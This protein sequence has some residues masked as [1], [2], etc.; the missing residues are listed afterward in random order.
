MN[1]M[2]TNAHLYQQTLSYRKNAPP[3]QYLAPCWFVRVPHPVYYPR[4][5]CHIE[6]LICGEEVFERLAKDLL[7]ARESVDIITWGFDPGMV[8]VRGSTAE[9]G[10]R[11]GDLLKEIATRK[12]KPV[13]VRLLV[14]HDDVMSNELMKN[15][16]GYYGKRFPGID[17]ILSS[18]YSESH[19]AYNAEWF[20]QVCAGDIPNIT[21]HVRDVPAIFLPRSLSGESAPWNVAADLGMIYA[22]HHQKMLLVD[23]ELPK[24]AR[25]Y[26]MGHNSITDFWD[27]KE[28]QFR[29]KRRER[30]YTTDH[31]DLQRSAWKLGQQFDIFHSGMTEAEQSEKEG[32][33]QSYIDAHSHVAQPYQDVSCRVRG[34]ILYDLN[35]NFCQAW[36]E[37]RRPSPLFCDLAKLVWL[38]PLHPINIACKVVDRMHREMD[39]D[40]IARRKKLS[41]AAFDLP[42]GHHSL[43][44][45]RTQPQHGEKSVKECY[46]NLTRQMLHYIFIQNQYIQYEPWAE[47]LIACV[48]LLRAAGY[49][50]PIYVFLLTSTPEKDGMDRPTYGVASKVGRSESMRFEHEEAVEKAQKQKTK[51][52]I[53]PEELAVQGIKVFMGS[54]WTCNE[55]KGKLRPD[56]YEEIYIH[57]KVAIV[58]D[59]AFTI[60]SANLNL[61]SMALDS[62]LN[63]LS[64]AKD[65][66]YQLRSDLFSQCAQETG[67]EPFG[68]MADTFK[69]WEKLAV[70]N[71]GAKA[72]G[73]KL[74]GNLLPFHVDRKPGMPVV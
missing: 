50:Q 68:D 31:A 9:D 30:F 67:P 41:L 58:D 66:A 60:G 49:L 42:Y 23:Y 2:S 36:Q 3:S 25:G 1:T 51:P 72:A 18:Y 33:V 29:D 16:P 57:A 20:S 8:L 47:Y 73:G 17:C 54:L 13:K 34:P 37:S 64:E 56:D 70:K 19:Q 10:T 65:V 35:H 62:E 74:M 38:P 15:I 43:Q 45:L 59:A 28:H 48:G 63:V 52:P 32:A 22:A 7:S 46:A 4:Y 39:P 14:W 12:E 53:T 71:F 24:L 26:V 11:Y 21:F 5:N 61:R 69:K 27:T 6:P 44:L 55:K 40:F